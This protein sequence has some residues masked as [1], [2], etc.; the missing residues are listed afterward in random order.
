MRKRTNLT[1]G[2]SLIEVMISMVVMTIIMAATIIEMQ[3]VIQQMHANGGANLILG[4]LRWARQLSI[5]RRRDIQVQFIGNNEIRLTQ[6]PILGAGGAPVVISDLLLSPTVFFTQFGGEPDTP[7]GFGNA[8][9]VDFGAVVGGP[10]VMLFQSNGTFIDGATG[11]AINGTVFIG[12]ATI[13]TSARAITLLGTTGRI[14]S[15]KG[16]GSGWIQ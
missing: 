16:T 1:S 12:V 2:F 8:S 10:P 3:P 9:P 13:P 15:Y 4:Q 7:D 14:R 5:A 6:L 11:A